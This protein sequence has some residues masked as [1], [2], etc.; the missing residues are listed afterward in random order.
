MKS[1]P[2]QACGRSHVGKVR[3]VNE[4]Y[5]LAKTLDGS[6]PWAGDFELSCQLEQG[7]V[8]LVVCDGLGGLGHGSLASSLT[9][10]TVAKNCDLAAWRNGIS[11][12]LTRVIFYDLFMAAHQALRQ[13]VERNKAAA[14]MATT[15]TAIILHEKG[16]CFGHVGDTKAYRCRDNKIQQL[17]TDHSH[18]GWLLKNNQL[19]EAEARKHPEKN[20]LTQALSSQEDLPDLEIG[21]FDIALG[22]HFL[23][24][25][26]GLT[27]GLLSR[28]MA[29]LFEKYE[30]APLSHA[31]DDMIRHSLK[32]SG[33]DNT[34]GIVVRLGERSKKGRSRLFSV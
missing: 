19:T 25:S 28:Q 4:D 29:L 31:I 9:A 16:G 17:T 32:N 23:L 24:C 33:H 21:F 11:E 30:D 15:L 3:K 5:L 22:D 20:I 10:Q 7:P 18:V 6:Q 34:S 27:D 2:L 14:G 12:D 8:L 1:I 26:D 13:E